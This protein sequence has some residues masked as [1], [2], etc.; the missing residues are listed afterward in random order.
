MKASEAPRK[1]PM[2]G[3]ACAMSRVT[4]TGIR[5]APPM[6]RLV[7]SN[8][9][10]PAPGMNTSTQA[11]VE[12]FSCEPRNIWLGMNKYPETMRAPKPRE[13]TASANKIAK[14]RHDPQPRSSGSVGDC[15]PSASR[16]WYETEVDTP[17]LISLRSE[18]VSVGVL[19]TND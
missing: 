18:R 8:V 1:L 5:L 3:T 19:A 14:S 2:T 7:G 13:R 15:V 17:A 16:L 11:W 4:A 9:T 12:P 10:H 6:L